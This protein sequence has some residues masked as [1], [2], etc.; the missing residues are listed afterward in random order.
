MKEDII[1][2]LSKEMADKAGNGMREKFRKQAEIAIEFL[3]A[4]YGPD[5]PKHWERPGS[6][7][8]LTTIVGYGPHSSG[9]H[10]H[11]ECPKYKTEIFPFSL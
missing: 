10:H 11:K 4:E 7:D 2:R 5:K 6:C 1:D 8:C 3:G 9:N